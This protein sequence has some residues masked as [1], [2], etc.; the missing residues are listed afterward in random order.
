MKNIDRYLMTFSMLLLSAALQAEVTVADLFGN[1][2]VLQRDMPVPVWGRAASGESV[3][4]TFADQKKTAAADP[5][6]RW[7]ITLQPMPACADGR[8]MTIQ[9]AGKTITLTDVY[10]GDVWLNLTPSWYVGEK[11]IRLDDDPD[12][13]ALPPI[14]VHRPASVHEFRNHSVRPQHAYSDG[15]S[16]WS[17]YLG[18]NKYFAADAYY[19]GMGL[20]PKTGASVGVIGVGISTLPSMTPP[21]GFLFLS[22]EL[23]ETASQVA[24]WVPETPQGKAAYRQSLDAVQTWIEKTEA[25]LKKKNVTFKDFTQPPALPG[26]PPNERSA[27]TFFNHVIARYQGAALRGIIIRPS[28]YSFGDDDYAVKARALILGLR[29]LFPQKDLP[30]CWVEMHAPNPHEKRQAKDPADWV[31]FRQQQ[32][33]ALAGLPNTALIKARDLDNRNTLDSDISRRVAKWAARLT[34]GKEKD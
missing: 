30:V 21:E 15:R 13:S 8:P 9:G 4:V 33:A 31:A 2:C 18:R 12:V 1:Q 32:K 10:V 17:R 26:P 25:I 23:G 22:K 34:T 29:A 16:H 3:T 6:G 14:C 11:P 5:F 24:T 28:T 20:A 19:L 27:T 7:K